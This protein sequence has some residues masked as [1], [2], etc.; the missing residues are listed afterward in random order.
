MATLHR[1]VA[2]TTIVDDQHA[3]RRKHYNVSRVAV[4]FVS[5]PTFE[6]AS[7]RCVN[8]FHDE[9]CHRHL[10]G[11]PMYSTQRTSFVCIG[12]IQHIFKSMASRETP[13]SYNPNP[14]AILPKFAFRVVSIRQVCVYVDDTIDRWGNNTFTHHMFVY[15]CTRKLRFKITHR[16]RHASVLCYAINIAS[17]FIRL[18]KKK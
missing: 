10:I 16:V 4:K 5:R 8:R 6:H 14:R 1:A 18:K 3:V 11:I 9:A 17:R 15:R 7:T 2:Y 13:A 12:G